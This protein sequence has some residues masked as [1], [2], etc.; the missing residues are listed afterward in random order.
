MEKFEPRLRR[1]CFP[2]FRWEKQSSTKK[3]SAAWPFTEPAVKF[4]VALIDVLRLDPHYTWIMPCQHAGK[5]RV[6]C[7]FECQLS[8]SDL[9]V[10][11]PRRD[12]SSTER[13]DVSP[14][15]CLRVSVRV[16]V[17]V[18]YEDTSVCG[19]IGTI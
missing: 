6:I 12:V 9:R 10:S 19:H 13:P 5:G 2:Q 14:Y 18:R 16:K 1:E 8:G 3:I 17:R 4:E 15:P 11:C 7:E